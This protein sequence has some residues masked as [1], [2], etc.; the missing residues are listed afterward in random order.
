[1][2]KYPIAIYSVI[3]FALGAGLTFLIM[4]SS[5][6][7][8]VS[9]STVPE[10][11]PLYWVAPMDPAYRR[12]EPGKSPMGM[13]LVPVYEDAAGE[14]I[15]GTVSISPNVEQN[16]GVKTSKVSRGNL[17]LSVDTVG[18]IQFNEDKINH[19]HSRVDG[20][21]ESLSVTAKGD[22]VEKGQKLFELYSPDLVNAQ[23]EYLAALNSGSSQLVEGSVKK[24]QSQGITKELIDSLKQTKKVKQRL[25]FYAS[26]AGY[27]SELN[28]RE[29]S[30]IKPA[31]NVLSVGALQDVW[32]IAEIFERQAGW[33]KNGQQVEM[34]TESYPQDRWSGT[35]DYLYPELEAGTRT[36]RAR[37]VF[38]NAD[39]RLKPNMFARLIIQAGQKT[40]VVAIPRQAVI[41]QG[42]MKRVVKALGNGKFR[43]IRIETGMESGDMIEVASGLNTGDEI[44]VSSQ[45]LIDSESSI[46]ADLTRI[47]TVDPD[48]E[49]DPEGVRVS[50]QVVKIMP[51]HKM[52]EVN[53]EPI[54]EWGWPAM[55]MSFVVDEKISLDTLSTGMHVRLFLIEDTDGEYTVK[56]LEFDSPS[57]HV[58]PAT[59]DSND[60]SN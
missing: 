13:D 28:V 31:T 26:Q 42:G 14:S 15:A 5:S 38:N 51:K 17:S 24:L 49:G 34:T 11:K 57:K 8:A 58:H 44:V 20:W 22:P 9:N 10:P 47:E 29:G 52:I 43:S 30:Y 59:N 53:H 50:A 60:H 16:L 6:D 45:F 2:N 21:I 56:K 12:D 37:I 48:M 19:F 39:L 25:P 35:V 46:S 40:G 1:M 55:T 32:V 27:V 18:F 36:L 41:Y 23:E 33:I 4:Q 54:P 3:F 7:S